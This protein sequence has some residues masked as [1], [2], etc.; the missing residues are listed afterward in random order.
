MLEKEHKIMILE[1]DRSLAHTLQTLLHQQLQAQIK[2]VSQV[3]HGVNLLDQET[4]DIIIADWILGCDCG[5]DVV[6]YAKQFHQQTKILM[7]TQKNQVTNR[8]QAYRLGA[9]AYLSKP[10][11][12]KEL[13]VLMRKLLA[14]YKTPSSKV[15]KLQ[16]LCLYPELSKLVVAGNEIDLRPKETKILQLLMINSPVIL[17]KEKILNLI[18]PNLDHRPHHN[19]VEVYIRRIR[20]KM[21]KYASYL[22]NKRCCGYYLD[23]GNK[24]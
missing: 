13:L 19:T 16:Q 14:F 18:W 4:F 3:Q 12:T 11:D 8:L 24:Q 10:F 6:Y 15:I 2:W 7:L 20:R 5:L 22:R 17:S 23:S 21:G 9:D 1:D